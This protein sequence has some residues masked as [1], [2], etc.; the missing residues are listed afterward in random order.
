MQT[1]SEN[2][3]SPAVDYRDDA[4]IYDQPQVFNGDEAKWIP[5][6]Q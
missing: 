2:Q 1:E 6:D 3:E 5:A 4:D